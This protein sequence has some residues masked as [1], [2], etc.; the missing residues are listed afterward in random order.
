MGNPNTY[1]DGAL[2]HLKF[3]VQNP[4]S[5]RGK[6]CK[7]VARAMMP[8]TG[9]VSCY[10]EGTCS[11]IQSCE[12]KCKDL[13]DKKLKPQ[14]VLSDGGLSKLNNCMDDSWGACTAYCSQSRMRSARMEDGSCRAVSSESRPCHIDACGSHN[15]C[16]VPFVVHAVIGLDGVNANLWT[17]KYEEIFVEAFASAIGG[18]GNIGPGDIDVLMTNVWNSEH[19][20]VKPHDER[21][22]GLR[23]ILE[24]SMFS[25]FSDY[26]TENMKDSVVVLEESNTEGE[27]EG[28]D[29]ES[30]T[31]C[32]GEERIFHLAKRA[33][34]LQNTLQNPS[35]VTKL[36]NRLPRPQSDQ[37]QSPFALAYTQTSVENSRVISSWTIKTDSGAVHKHESEKPQVSTSQVIK[38]KVQR[39]ITNVPLITSFLFVIAIIYVMINRLQYKMNERRDDLLSGTRKTSTRVRQRMS[40]IRGKSKYSEVGVSKETD[41]IGIELA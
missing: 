30:A 15:S 19:D 2:Q 5:G 18:L 38:E 12:L 9:S 40:S 39:N 25:D 37:I 20:S 41:T 34:E 33:L 3:I 17:K 10:G 6:S 4:G 27:G 8:G 7:D 23:L 16:R 36:L 28:E 32:G 14:I 13:E 26:Q 22:L 29:P 35:F 21:I 31:K 1:V 24:I 11:M